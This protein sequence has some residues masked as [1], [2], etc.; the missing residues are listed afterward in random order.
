MKRWL[1]RLFFINIVFLLFILILSNF[2]VAQTVEEDLDLDGFNGLVDCDDNNKDISPQAV[3]IVSNGVDDDCD[4][5]VDEGIQTVESEVNLDIIEEEFSDEELEVN[6][7][8]TP[9]SAFYFL[10]GLS[11]SREEKIAEIAKMIEEGNIDAAREAL[12]KY[13]E[14]IQDLEENPD[15]SIREEARRSTAKIN[16]ILRGLENNGIDDK[17]R[18]E[19]VDDVRNSEGEVVTAVEIADKIKD[20]CSELHKRGAWEEFERVCNMGDRGQKWQKDLFADLSDEQRK[21]AKEFFNIMM[22]CMESSGRECKCSDIPHDDFALKC[23]EV[24]PL[25]GLCDE[26][27]EGSCDKMDELTNGIE[28]LLPEHLKVVL[29]TVEDRFEDFGVS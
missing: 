3:E 8:L 6:P 18:K 5:L 17:F 23:A 26:G 20:L 13:N 29:E 2:V 27:D 14:Y 9:D 24:A 16:K 10:D 21:E 22:Q 15:P 25:A 28:D 19:F 11:D 1:N 4:T 12:N 7:G